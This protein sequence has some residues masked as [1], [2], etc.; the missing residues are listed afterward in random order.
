MNMN[1]N[2]MMM[3]IQG[4][5]VVNEAVA[6]RISTGESATLMQTYRGGFPVSQG[7]F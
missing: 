1:M 7:H 5:D 2:M 6:A 3:M 4:A